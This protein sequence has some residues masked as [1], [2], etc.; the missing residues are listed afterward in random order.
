MI[1]VEFF[2]EVNLKNGEDHISDAYIK[3]GPFNSVQWTYSHI[4]LQTDGL[5]FDLPNAGES[6]TY[7]GKHW[8][9][10]RICD[11][12]AKD[13]S[14]KPFK[15]EKKQPKKNT[16]ERRLTLVFDDLVNLRR[17]LIEQ[18]V[19]TAKE[20]SQGTFIQ[21][22]MDNIEIACDL[23]DDESDG[24]KFSN[25]KEIATFMMKDQKNKSVIEAIIKNLKDIEVDGE[26]M[27]HILEQVGMDE[28][29]H[30]QLIMSFPVGQTMQE[31]E[32]KEEVTGK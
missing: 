16:A 21:T 10:F 22:Y 11:Y 3:V 27:Q 6:V 4:R 5:D 8:G 28:Q 13:K 26:T 14:V 12:D 7:G 24:W 17:A 25:K 19:D 31:L 29:M 23:N 20:D 9:D 1:Q 30:H 2:N 15:I 18:G 32:L